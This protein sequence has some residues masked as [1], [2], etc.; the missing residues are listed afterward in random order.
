M[1]NKRII[2]FMVFYKKEIVVYNDICAQKY[3]FTIYPS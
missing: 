2:A 3:K 1:K